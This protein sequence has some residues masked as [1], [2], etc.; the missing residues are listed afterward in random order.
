MLVRGP[1]STIPSRQTCPL[2]GN[3]QK[4]FATEEKHSP[5][6]ASYS[7][8][9][10]ITM[11]T[12]KRRH[13]HEAVYDGCLEPYILRQYRQQKTVWPPFHEEGKCAFPL[14]LTGA[15]T[16]ARGSC[17]F[18]AMA[19]QESKISNGSVHFLQTSHLPG[20]Q[21]GK[22][23]FSPVFEVVGPKMPDWPVHGK[24]PEACVFQRHYKAFPAEIADMGNAIMP[25]ACARRARHDGRAVRGES[26]YFMVFLIRRTES[27]SCFSTSV[28]VMMQKS[29]V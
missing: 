1:F 15:Q 19:S 25:P 28:I 12:P 21:E 16:P 22:N 20:P 3:W 2:F 27:L 9:S 13:R 8:N 11:L 23:I 26:R 14:S 7:A 18:V 6:P 4:S 24:I 17:C 5:A 10:L 29:L